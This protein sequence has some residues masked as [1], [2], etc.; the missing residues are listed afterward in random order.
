MHPP[1]PMLKTHTT[2]TRTKPSRVHGA[3][4]GLA[5]LNLLTFAM[6]A[7][8]E[9]LPDERILHGRG[10]LVSEYAT[11]TACETAIYRGA[12][13]PL[14][15]N[16]PYHTTEPVHGVQGMGFCRGARHGT[17]VWILEVARTTTL[18]AFGNQAFGLEG[19]GW[20]LSDASVLV[21]AAGVPFD[22]V[23]TRRIE[24]G[25]FVIRQGFTRSAPIVFWDTKAARISAV[26]PRST[27]SAR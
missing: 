4:I 24:P 3:A 14:Y 22:R 13:T 25:R 7:C 19:R 17:N 12:E 8:D 23:Y 20:T 11:I 26:S 1:R 21:A 6:T 5:L 16:R 27:E 2:G 15:S 9:N 18:A 10:P